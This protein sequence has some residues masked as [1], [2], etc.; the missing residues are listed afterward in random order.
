M[1]TVS[2]KGRKG[3]E[4]EFNGLYT[5]LRKA[6]NAATGEAGAPTSVPVMAK[7]M[8]V[9]L[10]LLDR[11]LSAWFYCKEVGLREPQWHEVIAH[12]GKFPQSWTTQQRF[13][14]EC[15]DIPRGQEKEWFA[16]M[17]RGTYPDYAK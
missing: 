1:I 8:L 14:D 10:E 15:K 6:R 17:I 13:Y 11:Y 16:K 3:A 4:M 12:P 7:E 5:L 9:D 2:G